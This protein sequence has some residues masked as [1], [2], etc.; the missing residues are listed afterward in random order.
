MTATTGE[1]DGDYRVFNNQSAMHTAAMR[2]SDRLNLIPSQK[3]DIHNRSFVEI[4]KCEFLS[5][6]YRAATVFFSELAGT[7][8]TE[9]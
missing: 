4:C 8:K 3:S 9:A 5:D 6:A 7:T 1:D 2:A